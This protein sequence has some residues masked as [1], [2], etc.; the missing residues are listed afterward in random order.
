VAEVADK[1][2]VLDAFGSGKQTM[3]KRRKRWSDSRAQVSSGMNMASVADGDVL[4]RNPLCMFV[5]EGEGG[6]G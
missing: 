1:R 3:M 4:G 2:V 6:G 5:H